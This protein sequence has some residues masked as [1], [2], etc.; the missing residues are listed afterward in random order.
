MKSMQNILSTQH[1]DTLVYVDDELG[2]SSY[3]DNAKGKIRQFVSEGLQNEDYPF[4]SNIEVWEEEFER[5]WS[6]ANFGDVWTLACL[7]NI[8]RSIPNIATKLMELMPAINVDMLAPEQF[9]DTYKQALI[10]KLCQNRTNAIILVDFDLDGYSINGDHLLAGI[11]TQKN[12]FCGIFSQTFDV[13]DEIHK[14]EERNFNK[15]IYP[16]S[17]KRFEEDET[18]V[19]IIQGIKNVIWLKQIGFIKETASKVANNALSILEDGLRG[20]DPATFDRMVIASAKVEGC[21]EFENL[22]RVIQIYIN[23]G[24]RDEIKKLFPDFQAYTKSLRN[25]S[26]SSQ[27]E[28]VNCSILKSIQEDEFFENIDYINGVYSAVT[29]GDIFQIGDKYYILLGQPCNLAIREGKRANQLDQAYLIPLIS[30]T[31]KDMC[32]KLQYPYAD[33]YSFALFTRRRR[34][35]LSL[36]DLVSYN[37]DGL[38]EID[39]NVDKE[40]VVGHEIMQ[41]NMLLRYEKI[42]ERIGSYYRAYNLVSLGKNKEEKKQIAVYF[43]KPFEMGEAPVAKSPAISGT[44]ITFQVKRVGRYYAY[45]AHVLL[46]QFMSYM[47]RPDFP[48]NFNRC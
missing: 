15:N 44:K 22:L 26:D 17:K 5:W 39:I 27:K 46:Q 47:S 25:F 9:D 23:K 20:I 10:D 45:G 3:Y 33:I 34:V 41:E 24:I 16:I 31:E 19:S 32:G 8:Q 48:V 14:W 42:R 40:N 13:N 35:S 7:Y 38:A 12:V 36:L 1:I 11:G 29:N 2:K 43:C 37:N 4:F 28:N 30:E 18:N 21:W 6:L